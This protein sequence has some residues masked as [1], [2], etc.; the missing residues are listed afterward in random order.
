MKKKEDNSFQLLFTALVLV[1]IAVGGTLAWFAHNTTSSVDQ[2]GAS[3]TYPTYNNTFGDVP[4]YY[5]E[6]SKYVQYG[7]GSVI[8][9]PG[10]KRLF[11]VQVAPG[12][13]EQVLLVLDGDD[14]PTLGSQ[15]K[16]QFF[17]NY[18]NSWTDED[19]FPTPSSTFNS[20]AANGEFGWTITHTIPP[21]NQSS[22]IYFVV[23]MDPSAGDTYQGQNFY[24]RVG[25]PS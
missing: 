1:V 13:T 21:G 12:A 2:M 11:R 18:D 22:H 25:V 23:Y 20:Q 19:Y 15:M 7:D 10:M 4:L 3:V 17:D 8:F 16:I 14:L 5:L 9:V 24:F 6:G